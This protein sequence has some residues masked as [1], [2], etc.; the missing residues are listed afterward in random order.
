MRIRL[1]AFAALSLGITQTVFAQIDHST[2]GGKSSFAIP[3]TAAVGLNSSATLQAH[4]L[5]PSYV[6]TPITSTSASTATAAT[7]NTSAS[8]L[9]QDTVYYGHEGA[10][11]EEAATSNYPAPLSYYNSYGGLHQG[12]NVSLG[13]S[14]FAQF[15]KNARKGAGFTQSITATYLQ[16]LGKKAWL[17]VGGYVDHTN[18]SG[19]NYT[20]G[21]LYGE[22]G[23]QF[24]EHWAAYVY[25][26]KSIVNNGVQAYGYPYAGGYY[27]MGSP[28]LY[29]N[30]GDKLGAALRWTPNHNFSMEIS[31]E[32]NWYPKSSFG[33]SDNYKY[34]YPTPQK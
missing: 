2:V 13:M 21:G 25:G 8:A 14:V 15:G 18:W 32:K 9:P 12:L 3:G 6:T 27:G 34:N 16:P 26:K 4:T 5:Q 10:T 20:T 22:L 11:P 7:G 28:Y 31:V 29:N 24:N 19:D 23:Y 1:F 30:L 17:A 33:Y